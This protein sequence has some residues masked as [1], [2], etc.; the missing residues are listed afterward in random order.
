MEEAE[1]FYL[2][3]YREEIGHS[4]DLKANAVGRKEMVLQIQE[5]GT[6]PLVRE[7]N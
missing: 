1:R 5:N 7:K 3:I 6:V 2:F 4:I